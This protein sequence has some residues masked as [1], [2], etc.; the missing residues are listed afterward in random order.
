LRRRARALTS[1]GDNAGL[2]SM[3]IG[4]LD[5]IETAESMRD[6][7]SSLSLPRRRFD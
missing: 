2:S 1:V 3:N 6:Q 5:I 4:A 7:S